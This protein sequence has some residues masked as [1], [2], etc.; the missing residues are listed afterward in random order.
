MTVSVLTVLSDR[1]AWLSC[2][3]LISVAGRLSGET[4]RPSD[5]NVPTWHKIQIQREGSDM[6]I[7]LQS[8]SA[9]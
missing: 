3:A 1:P 7:Y 2:L 9:S 4:H 8:I 5:F 6:I